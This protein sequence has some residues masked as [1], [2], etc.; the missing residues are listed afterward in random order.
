MLSVNQ[1][2][3]EEA[4]K[5]F[6]LDINCLDA[7]KPWISK[8][9]IFEILKVSRAEIRHSNILAWLL[10]A[11]EN[12]GLDDRFIRAIMH[13]LVQNYQNKAYFDFKKISILKLLT[14]DYSN[15]TVVREW[16]NIDIL[17]FS[18]EN[19]LV[20][21]IENKIGSGEH[22]NQLKRY[23]TKIEEAYPEDDGYNAIYIY[24]TPEKDLPSDTDNWIPFSYG[25]ILIILK[26]LIEE[27]KLESSI[28]LI[29][30]NYMDILRRFVVKDKELVDICMN[31]YKKHRQALDL[32][33]ENKPDVGNLVADIIKEYLSN[34]SSENGEIIFEPDYSAKTIQRFSTE[35][36]NEIFPPIPDVQ[37]GWGNG[38]NYFWEIINNY[39]VGKLQVKFVMCNF[40]EQN[41][42]KAAKLAKLLSKELKEKWQWK[43]F[44]T[45]NIELTSLNQTDEFLDNNYDE[46]KS[47][48]FKKL[49]E[50]MKKVI[51][52]QE[53]VH[54]KWL[55]T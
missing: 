25:E 35:M 11:N 46:I 9:N 27:K 36:F 40:E 12:H 55:N 14:L 49:N 47:E 31:I 39:S 16:N 33:F 1:Q 20:I 22:G 21:C 3:N 10:N 34:K 50:E 26:D 15:F 44:K 18:N 43:T 38:R 19:K 13:K 8:V 24:L 7:L 51:A 48:V 41:N 2:R 28:K 29:I 23:K 32:I 52:F 54:K 45:F 17:L 30:E 37:G 6:L 53:Q 4:I 5:A 42:N